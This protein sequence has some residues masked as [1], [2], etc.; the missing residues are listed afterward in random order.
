MWTDVASVPIAMTGAFLTGVEIDVDPLSDAEVEAIQESLR[1][2][3]ESNPTS[4]AWSKSLP[5]ETPQLRYSGAAYE[6]FLPAS[7]IQTPWIDGRDSRLEQHLAQFYSGPD[8]GELERERQ[9]SRWTLEQYQIAIF[10]FGV[11]TFAAT[12]SVD[13]AGLHDGASI[14]VTVGNCKERLAT[15]LNSYL[16]P[17]NE[18]VRQA[19]VATCGRKAVVPWIHG[20]SNPA[21][22]GDVRP[23]GRKGRPAASQVSET[24]VGENGSLLWVHSVYLIDDPDGIDRFDVAAFL[25]RK[26]EFAGLNYFPGTESSLAV[27]T[28][29]PT[30]TRETERRHL[31]KVVL[32][33]WA[34]FAAVAEIDRT[35]WRM[36]SGLQTALRPRELELRLDGVLAFYA[37][38]R[39][40]RGRLN[41]SL[42]DYGGGF[43]ALWNAGAAVQGLDQLL[44]SADDKLDATQ[45]VCRNKLER[46]AALRERRLNRTVA[47][48]TV[49]AVVSSI[50]AVVAF[51][52]PPP[53]KVDLLRAALVLAVV[54]FTIALTH[55]SRRDHPAR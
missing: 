50:V 20:R 24:V 22:I 6:S 8:G 7:L 23:A 13:F 5:S 44:E 38:V 18:S 25:H 55:F 29:A 33:A 28:E 12:F 35:L 54:G 3:F 30:E 32:F 16:G 53:T 48:F 40:L 31:L 21:L 49:F 17:I 14:R 34:Y 45:T 41:T 47:L 9:G 27:W 1:S 26:H 52:T 4:V 42:A 43:I 36:L 19:A 39:V 10:P 51:F 46:L 2:W 37:R 15:P 11:G